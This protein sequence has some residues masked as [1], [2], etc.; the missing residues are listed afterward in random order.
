MI[1]VTRLNGSEISINPDMIEIVEE[2]PDT[3]IT[4][5]NG[6][7]YLVRETAAMILEKIVNYKAAIMHRS[8]FT[9]G[10]KYLLKKRMGID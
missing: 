8:Q 4:L 10:K 7:R 3:H 9:V 6:N 2:T 1:K 5:S